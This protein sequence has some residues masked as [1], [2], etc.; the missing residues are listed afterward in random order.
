MRV[1]L[2]RERAKA[3]KKGQQTRPFK[4]LEIGIAYNELTKTCI[5][6]LQFVRNMDE[7]IDNAVNEF[8]ELVGNP[9]ATQNQSTC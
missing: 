4:I 3:R 9:H 1:E 5:I 6:S 2:S 8:F 7:K